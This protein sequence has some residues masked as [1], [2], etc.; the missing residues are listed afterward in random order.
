MSARDVIA[1]TKHQTVFFGSPTALV[2]NQPSYI[3]GLVGSETADAI[4][5]ALADA[6]YAIVPVTLL[7]KIPSDPPMSGLPQ[8][9]LIAATDPPPSPPEER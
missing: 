1:L 9:E 8:T 5:A 6:N 2:E 4:L 7:A 3:V